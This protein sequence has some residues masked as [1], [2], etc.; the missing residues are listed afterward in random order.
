MNFTNLQE[1][2][3]DLLNYLKKEGYTESYVRIIREKIQWILKNEKHKSWQSYLD[4]YNDRVCK[5]ES[6]LYK[7][8]LR[9]AFGAIQQFDLN[10]EF[11]NRKVRNFLIKRGA[12]HQLVPEF[13]A[14]KDFYKSSAKL[15][16]LKESTIYGNVSGASTFLRAMQE[17]D[18]KSL[19]S[20][21]EEDVLSF[22]TDDEGNVSKCSSYKKEI[23][24]VFKAEDGWKEKE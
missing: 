1:H 7:K 6:K 11:P 12:Y 4:V 15:G 20:I 3:H 16:G 2:Y 23:A 19:G 8:N 10:G 24:A 21:G 13:K 9:I 18:I 22:F 5:S 17:R 14:V